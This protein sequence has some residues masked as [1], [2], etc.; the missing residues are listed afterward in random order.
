MGEAEGAP[1][2]VLSLEGFGRTF[3]GGL[4]IGLPFLMLENDQVGVVGRDMGMPFDR[5][6]L[7]QDLVTV[8]AGLISSLRD[9]DPS[10]NISKSSL[11]KVGLVALRSGECSGLIVK[12]CSVS[13]SLSRVE[14]DGPRDTRIDV[15]ELFWLSAGARLVPPDDEASP[16][17]NG[18]EE[19]LFEDEDPSRGRLGPEGTRG[20]S[21]I[22]DGGMESDMSTGIDTFHSRRSMRA[23]SAA[24][25]A[26][27]VH[28]LQSVSEGQV[29][30]L[31]WYQHGMLSRRST[32]WMSSTRAHSGRN[33]FPHCAASKPVSYSS[34]ARLL[35]TV[36]STT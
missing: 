8:L 25:L 3:T 36:V 29:C 30:S 24:S 2:F 17:A 22:D 5:S 12:S 16:R 35:L 14:E 13:S 7:D 26:E 1:R 9:P 10:S 6:S 19:A 28:C 31:P 33:Q 20:R 34:I 21:L 32:G 4:L 27:R 23:T 18:R 11:D 15:N